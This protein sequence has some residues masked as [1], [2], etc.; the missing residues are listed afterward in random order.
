MAIKDIRPALRAFLLADGSV[1]VAVGG[2]RVFPV[3]LP[4][5]ETRDSVVYTRISGVGDH[6][7][8]GPSGLNRPR[9]QIG[10]WSKTADGA[11]SLADLVKQCIDGHSG[12]M[13]AGG[14]AVDVQGVF[15]DSERDL[16]DDGAKLHGVIRD[17]FV[18]YE[19]R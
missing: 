18:W 6:H 13:G 19:E 15:F 8:T 5:G 7:M 12:A 17:Y 16:Y 4:Q 9:I 2:S 14:I 1:S 3:M 11:A 10:A